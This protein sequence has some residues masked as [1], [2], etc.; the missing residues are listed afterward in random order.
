ML[1][2]ARRW[3][4]AK[5]PIWPAPCTR[6]NFSSAAS[7]V[8]EDVPV[9]QTFEEAIGDKPLLVRDYIRQALYHPKFGYFSSRPDVVGSMREPLDFSGISG[10]FAYRKHIAEL[11]K[12]NDMSW[13]TPVELFQPWY[14]FAVAEYI[15][16]TMN[17]QFPL[18]IYE[19][20]GG[21][22]TCASN[23][24]GY[25][26]ERQGDVYKTM[27]Y[28]SVDVSEGLANKQ[29]HRLCEEE[30]HGDKFSVECR[31]ARDKSGWGEQDESPC[32]VVM[33]EVL[34]NMPHDLLFRESSKSP[35]METYVQYDSSESRFVEHHRPVEDSLVSR[36]LEILGKERDGDS[37]DVVRKLTKSVK[38]IFSR[39]LPSPEKWWI[40]T[41][42]ME[43]LESLHYAR[44][45]MVMV[46]SDFSFLP[47]VK[48][49]GRGAPL[50]SSKK[51]GVTTDYS[52]YL[53]AKGEADIFFPTDFD[54]L[55]I[56]D[57]E[58]AISQSEGKIVPNKF[59]VYRGSAIM[60][61][62]NFM[63]R[64]AYVNQVKTKSGFNP[65]L[66]EYSNTKVYLSAPV[67]K[68]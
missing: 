43:L 39:V 26:R 18:K 21:T 47:E 60:S 9:P 24:L 57:N 11:Y 14:G 49:P 34:D 68:G 19:I 5:A 44:P 52:S 58:C 54:Q 37:V 6:G 1:A 7:Q 12:Q 46:V 62:S 41:G 13:F 27:H 33:L 53:D 35:W 16:Q 8:A 59:G 50:V 36:C 10:R 64:F 15:L 38:S 2:L 28:T 29:R 67:L 48:I 32:Y 22:G 65:L 25:I 3:R 42:C 45:N 17:P 4:S 61:S 40:P 23:V 20:G 51:D 31:N 56:L 63:S 66:D 30:E 55:L